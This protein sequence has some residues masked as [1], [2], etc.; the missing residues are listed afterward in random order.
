M[1][2]V[3][4]D[5]KDVENDIAALIDEINRLRGERKELEEKLSSERKAF[6]DEKGYLKEQLEILNEEKQKVE[7]EKEEELKGL[8]EKN[9]QLKKSMEEG[10]FDMV[11]TQIESLIDENSKLRKE[12]QRL[13]QE[14]GSGTAPGYK[15]RI[16]ASVTEAAEEKKKSL[17]LK[18]IP[19]PQSPKSDTKDVV[20]KHRHK[21]V[22][23]PAFVEDAPVRLRQES[24]TNRFKFSPTGASGISVS[25]SSG[26]LTARKSGSE[27]SRY[28]SYATGSGASAAAGAS[29][30]S[31]TA[32]G[33]T[34]GSTA[35][36][37][38]PKSNGTG[39][40]S[41]NVLQF[42]TGET[43]MTVFLD[44]PITKDIWRCD[45]RFYHDDTHSGTTAD[46]GVCDSKV[47]GR[48]FDKWLYN[49]VETCVYY[50]DKSAARICIGKNPKPLMPA[51]N[52]KNGTE[53]GI[54]IDYVIRQIRFYQ[55]NQ[56]VP[57][58]VAIRPSSLH[59]GITGR[60][61]QR[62]EAISLRRVSQATVRL[63]DKY[64]QYEWEKY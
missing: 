3:D 47:I 11:K 22:L 41:M 62:M 1:E 30:G 31:G 48:L 17:A 8:E 23:A 14:G 4:D 7:S 29:T 63:A 54:E 53:I 57:F 36:G 25:S 13:K 28:V 26:G 2:S 39:S 46:F 18:N 38:S 32:R 27:S 20:E 24:D 12:N 44:F 43:A 50:L 10:K 56:P 35:R 19:S 37:T 59:V 40:E 33:K 49:N 5:Y 15:V 6:E 9:S 34:G 16:P 60:Y 58:T 61:Q 55:N 45:L 64:P 21:D 42:N 51:F 52:V